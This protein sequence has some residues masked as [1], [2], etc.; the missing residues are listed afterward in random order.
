MWVLEDWPKL[1]GDNI[2]P[3]SPL[4]PYPQVTQL[5]R[6]SGVGNLIQMLTHASWPVGLKSYLNVQQKMQYA[7]KVPDGPQSSLRSPRSN[8]A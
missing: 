7:G 2:P 3:P 8:T 6:I 1:S 4:D 5:T